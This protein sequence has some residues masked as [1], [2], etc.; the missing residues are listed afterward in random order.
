M[1]CNQFIMLKDYC[2]H[3]PNLSKMKSVILK[4]APH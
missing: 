3:D 4:C 1:T 2:Q